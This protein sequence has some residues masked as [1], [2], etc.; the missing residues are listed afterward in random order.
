MAWYKYDGKH[1][2][3]DL[4]VARDDVIEQVW[5]ENGLAAGFRAQMVDAGVRIH[6]EKRS[7]FQFKEGNIRMF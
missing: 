3:P 5:R 6:K 4:F 2:R 7:P 1:K